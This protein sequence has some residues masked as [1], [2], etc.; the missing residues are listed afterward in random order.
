MVEAERPYQDGDPF[1]V[2][3]GPGTRAITMRRSFHGVPMHIRRGGD[4]AQRELS[5]NYEPLVSSEDGTPRGV[6]VSFHDVTDR[7]RTLEELQ[8][9]ASLVALSSDFVAIAGLDQRVLYINEAGRKLVGLTSIEQARALTI[10]E[11]L[12]EEGLRASREI[13]QP[14]VRAT[15]RWEGEGSLRH[16]TTG[17]EIP[18]RIS[19]Y[20]VRH[21]DTNEPWALATIQRDISRSNA[22]RPA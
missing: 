20:L 17:A 6:L 18:V 10:P 12:T 3:T 16:V 9:F 4:G 5:V 22:P 1:A 15:G 2:D 13:E 11:L 14:A 19:S 7:Q 8:Q 21:P